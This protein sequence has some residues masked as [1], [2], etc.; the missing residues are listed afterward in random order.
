MPLDQG[1]PVYLAPEMQGIII[2]NSPQV[3][4]PIVEQDNQNIGTATPAHLRQV[5]NPPVWL[6]D[7][8]EHQAGNFP[9][10]HF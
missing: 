7:F 3:M 1:Q 5:I 8:V 4:E 6:G 2:G 9:I 10:I